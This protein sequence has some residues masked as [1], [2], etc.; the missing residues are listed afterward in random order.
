MLNVGIIGGNDYDPTNVD[1]TGGTIEGTPIGQSDPRAGA[2]TGINLVSQ[3]INDADL[4]GDPI[5]VRLSDGGQYLYCKFYP[6]ASAVE[7]ATDDSE[8]DDLC[9]LENGDLSGIP[10]TVEV[11]SGG[12]SYY[13]KGYP[14]I[15]TAT[16]NTGQ[17]T[18]VLT[19]YVNAT[20]SGT[21]RV[22]KILVDGT[23]YYAKI[24][25]NMN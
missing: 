4:S 2:F 23:P 14:S 19:G 7:G 6:T 8:L 13:L 15:T 22:M 20:L 21:P 18:P 3:S 24:Y 12:S 10:V 17:K 9:V 16:I 5:I 11:K 25:P 1:I